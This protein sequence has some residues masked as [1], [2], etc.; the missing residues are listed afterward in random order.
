MNKKKILGISLGLLISFPTIGNP[1]SLT[2]NNNITPI[3]ANETSTYSSYVFDSYSSN[4]STSKCYAGVDLYDY[5][6]VT[7]TVILQKKNILGIWYDYMV[8]DPGETFN[9]VIVAHHNYPYKITKSGSY[10]CKYT[11]T[12]TVNGTTQTVTGYSGTLEV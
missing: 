1:N 8:G 2:N 10:R 5:G 9:N 7:I 11:A 12:G 6:D 4:V 3:H